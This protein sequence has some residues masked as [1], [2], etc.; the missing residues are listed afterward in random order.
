MNNKF[1]NKIISILFIFFVVSLNLLGAAFAENPLFEIRAKKV[2]YTNNNNLIIATGSA[3]ATNEF[4]KKI[5]SNEIIYDKKNSTIKT[6]GDSIYLDNE[7]N[8]LL[9]DTFFYDLNS[10]I[11]KAKK[12]VKYIDIAA[13]EFNFSYFEYNE[14]LEYGI[15]QDF[16][17][18]LKDESSAESQI[19][20]IDNKKAFT[21]MQSKN[22]KGY[23]NFFKPNVNYYTT[24]KN[25]KKSSGSIQERCTD[26][27][28]TSQKTLHDKNKKMLYHDHAVVRLRNIPVFYTPYFSHP[29]PSVKRMSG[30]LPPSTKNFTDLGRTIKT[31]YFW[32]I[33]PNRDLTF[34][35]IFYLD[36]NSIF[37]SEYRQQNNNSNFYV[38]SSYS[39]G[40]RN[41][42]KIDNDGNLIERTSGSRNHL[43]FGFTGKY[44]NLL[45]VENDL[46][47]NIQRISQ[48]NYLKVN[49]INT[50][51]VK[52]DAS[53]LKNNIHLNSYTGNKRIEL[54]TSIYESLNTDARNTKYNYTI[55]SITYSNYFRKY[56]QNINFSNSF[57]AKNLGGDSN[58]TN[59]ANSITLT[60]DEK[61]YKILDGVSN[62]FKGTLSNINYYN[63]NIAGD[64]ENFNSDA[65]II[66]GL[67]NAYP[68]IKYNDNYS[69]EQI[70][71]PKIFSKYTPGE[72]NKITSNEVINYQ[73]I[74][75]MNRKGSM[76]NPE[77]GF[78]VGYGLEYE[79]NK[80]STDN[81]VYMNGKFSAG[82]V[83]RNKKLKEMPTNSSL[84]E[85]KSHF[86]GEAS[87][88]LNNSIKSN[89]DEQ[90]NFSGNLE[91]Q[92]IKIDYKY[93]VTNSLNK[94]LKNDVGLTYLNKKNEF[95]GV[96][97]ETHDLGNEQYIDLNYTRKFDNLLNVSTGI[98]KNLETQFTESN[99][100]DMYYDSDCLKI[101]LSLTKKFY[102]SEDVN[103]SKN[104]ILSITLKPFGS[105]VAPNLTSLLTTKK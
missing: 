81:E 55:P 67:Q 37:L 7:G 38:D 93:I 32:V 24:C 45:L 26:W 65:N 35:P 72:M 104:F 44:D 76:S 41:L 3:E 84:A 14:N 75:S 46:N 36:E 1:L 89:N 40:Y 86:A 66:F 50:E 33:D 29:D 43:F 101:G 8:K 78:S 39:K 27:S 10:N 92:G 57:V 73:D 79:I 51:F 21:T 13:N 87:F 83:L 90:N 98:R 4:G 16:I 9:A 23:F 15:G 42:N 25:L 105:P 58:K 85:T 30:F 60:S 48:K 80:K 63:E 6:N 102:K 61:V 19:A 74:Y 2:T 56:N 59:Q 62:V 95:K 20:K 88:Y 47:I 82:Q 77:R 99:F 22:Q 11:I 52:E 96:Y 5:F 53:T 17:A 70:L 34:T 54:E 18:S 64:K 94:I 91:D 69:K 31:P 100:I 103:T 68:L 12:N 97:Y 28:I 49:Q 71:T